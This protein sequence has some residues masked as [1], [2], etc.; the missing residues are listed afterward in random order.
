MKKTVY[1]GIAVLT[2]LTALTACNNFFHELV[3]PDDNRI[4]SF[5]LPGQIGTARIEDTGIH[6]TVGPSVDIGSLLPSVSVSA[7]AV[8]LPVTLP[9]I[10]RT[11]PSGTLFQEVMG[12][13]A[14]RNQAAYVIDLI[15]ENQDFTVPPLDEAIDFSGP[16]TFLVVSGLGTIRQYTVTVEI[17]TGETNVLSFGFA[18]FHNPDL[19]R[20]DAAGTVDNTARTIDI[21]VWYPVENIGSFRLVPSFETNGAAVSE[22]GGT[23][24]SAGES[25]LAF[26][27]PP[28]ANW[29]TEIQTKILTVQRPGFEPAHYT[30]TVHFRE[31]PDTVRSIIDFRFDQNINYGI[32]YTVMGEIRD[33]GDTGLITVRVH[34]TGFPPA[35]LS[36]S[37]VSPGTVRVGGILQTSGLSPHN[38]TQ[39]VEYTV[40]SRDGMYTRT[41][42]VV[43]DFVNED[44]ARPRIQGF[45]FYR[46]INPGLAANTEAMIDHEAGI[47]VIE[48]VYTAEPPPHSLVPQ[49]SAG[50]VVS[51]GGTI[52]NSGLNAQDFS[53][54][55]KY[56]VTDPGNPNLYREYR[57]ETRY[58]KDSPS[59]AE[60][61]EFWFFAED[62]P[63]LCA[64]VKADIDQAAGTISAVLL[65]EDAGNGHRTLVPRWQAR[66]TVEVGGFAQASGAGGTVFSPPAVYRA[67]SVDRLFHKDYTVS[68][69]EINARL[70]VDQDATGDNSG[71]SWDNAFRSLGEACETLAYLPEGLPAEIWIA[72]GT[73]RPSE[74]GDQAA[75]FPVRGN[76]GYYGG[77]AG[78]ETE[79]DQRVPGTHTV[80]IT[81][82]LGGGV[83]SEHLFISDDRGYGLNGRN[84]AFGE[85]TF[86]K[87]RALTGPGDGISRNGAAISVLF[88]GTLTIRNAI[89]ED[90]QAEGVGGAV[91]VTTGIDSGGY[92]S[93][94]SVD[95]TGCSF[96]DTHGYAGGAINLHPWNG[97]SVSITDCHFTDTQANSDGGGAVYINS[98]ASDPVITVAITNCDFENTRA[99]KDGGAVYFHPY[100]FGSFIT[101]TGC[102]FENIQAG[103]SGGA[104]YASGNPVSIM[105]CH[106]TDIQ[107][108]NSGGA[109]YASGSSL[110]ITGC[111]FENT[112]GNQG[113]AVYASSSSVTITDC[114][115]INTQAAGNYGGAVYAFTSA[116]S[117]TIRGCDFTDT[118][119]VLSN[120]GAV[121]ARASAGSVTIT[122]CGFENIRA[123]DYAGA[124]YASCNYDSSVTITIR[125]CDFTDTQANTSGGAVYASGSSVSSVTITGCNFKNT[126]VNAFGGAVYTSSSSVTITEC[127]FKNIQAGSDGGAVNAS[128]AGSVTIT[129]CG[130]TD[131]QAGNSNRTG[132]TFGG[133]LY[134]AGNM[135]RVTDVQITN[136]TAGLSNDG[137]Y[138]RG[139]GIYIEKGTAALS[140][141]SFTNVKAL[142]NNNTAI[143]GG[144]VFFS[145]GTALTMTD[146]SI[147][148]AVSSYAGGAVG[149][150]GPSTTCTLSGVSF[151][152]CSAPWGS[153][154]YGNKYTG[155][156]G[157]PA[158]TV[159][160]GC[161]VNGTVITGANWSLFT[162][163]V[164]LVNGA[165]IAPGL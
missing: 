86:T 127:D 126:Q 77:F 96:T 138:S 17:D 131:I 95:I 42:Q 35:A 161:S 18:K 70:Y 99:N 124:V 72:E 38:F 93:G 157:A 111:G 71:V 103:T 104:V 148:G 16:V 64:T 65:F 133:S 58:V 32:R 15:K 10:Q 155:I 158:Y 84:A 57:V 61:S 143:I 150:C 68:V 110:A 29:N 145:T 101:I 106:F 88:A 123:G 21:T 62:N 105:D 31:D 119:S 4:R 80:T 141:V 116:G 73:Y 108:N 134:L 140:H 139:G 121:Y 122:D 81:G 92:I 53:R 47:M 49:F 37:F 153:L 164:Y 125:D 100:Y 74:T 36:P 128:A 85:M 30:L 112:R 27:K 50:G 46:D 114:G 19:T 162:S 160:P 159:G 117:I 12:L 20:G 144:A 98:F 1:F 5:S 102:N 22:S 25:V 48:A 56:R 163:G 41:Y 136:S 13:Y 151:S 135:I 130:F 9:Y 142:G 55:V 33:T 152:G 40:V 154:L 26:T 60:I 3:P 113:G 90:L 89:F 118:Q 82:D 54:M 97:G 2:A 107:A 94:G 24:L 75:Y 146:C 109:I 6:V 52:Q 83:Y 8:L 78:T 137:Y 51:V 28:T 66:W 165:T 14:S 23:A 149:G 11:F 91:N 76:T 59:L 45:G 39:P 69:R 156:D 79:K 34:H 63:G 115:F 43:V 120:A 129:N 147:S 44:D 7:K 132:Y 67:V 87:A